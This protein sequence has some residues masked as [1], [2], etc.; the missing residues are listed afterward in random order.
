MKTKETLCNLCGETCSLE[1]G[2]ED[3]PGG[4]IDQVVIG[5]Y[6]S[7]PGNGG[8]ALDDSTSYR[9]SMCEF[10][11]DWLFTEFKIPPSVHDNGPEVFL[12]ASKRVSN[13]DWRKTKDKFYAEAVRR[14]D[15]RVKKSHGQ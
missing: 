1:G 12:S 4:L 14:S 13:D 10:C 6:C 8:G 15:L 5:G 2:W 7:T 9:F 11:L 3:E